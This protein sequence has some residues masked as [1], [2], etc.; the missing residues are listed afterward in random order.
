MGTDGLFSSFSLLPEFGRRLRH[1]WAAGLMGGTTIGVALF[2]WTLV[3]QPPHWA[4]GLILVGALLFSAYF[5][6]RDEFLALRKY[7]QQPPRLRAYVNG[8]IG[9]IHAHGPRTSD[10]YEW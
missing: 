7:Q 5:T 2:V 9:E 1:H 10:S 8:S 3:G 6:W 4:V